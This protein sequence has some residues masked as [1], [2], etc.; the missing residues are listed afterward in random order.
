LVNLGENEEG[1]D[2]Y[3]ESLDIENKHY[4]ESETYEK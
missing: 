3:K 2:Y 4:K 1:L